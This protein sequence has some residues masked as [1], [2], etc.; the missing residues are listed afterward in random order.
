MTAL[1]LINQLLNFMAPA[2]FVALFVVLA[3]RAFARILRS[4]SPLTL[5]LSAQIAIV[6]V[7]SL[8]L[9]VAGLVIFGRDGKMASYALLAVGA[10]TCQWVLL[11]GWKA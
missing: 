10:A 2:A 3:A 11:R 7:A 1:N 9:L 6:F 4:K 5:S 8:T